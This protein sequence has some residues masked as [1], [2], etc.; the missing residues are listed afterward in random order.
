MVTKPVLC[1]GEVLLRFSPPGQNL[2]F[3][4]PQLDVCF[5]GAEANVAVALAQLGSRARMLS[6]LPANALGHAAREELRRR[7]VEVGAIA[8]QPGRMGLYFLFPGALRRASEV[9]YD[10]EGSAFAAADF[11]QFDWS[12]EL[13]S[14]AALHVSGIT[15]AL[16]PGSAEAAIAVARA[17][18]GAELPVSFDCNFRAQ[19]WSAW[20]GDAVRILRELIGCT[21]TLFA[22]ERDVARVLDVPAPAGDPLLRRRWAAQAAF[23]RF[24]RLERVASTIRVVHDSARHELGAVLFERTGGEY[25]AAPVALTGIVDRIG[26]GDAF[27]GGLLHAQMAG[28]PPQQAVE[29]ALAAGSLKHAIR[30]DF[31]LATEATVAATLRD[32]VRDVSR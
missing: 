17:A 4:T 15:A 23:E 9:L 21:T 19:L 12:G 13:S 1:F 2:L 18:V 7:G 27:A 31:L 6:V 5:G 8:Q 3:Q 25:R 26:A 22:D 28:V 11:Q 30:G 29:F 20:Q 14:A 10:R 32:D 24:P 16:G